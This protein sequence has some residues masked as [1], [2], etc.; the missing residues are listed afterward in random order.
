MSK[1]TDFIIWLEESWPA[2]TGVTADQDDALR[3]Y[4][5]FVLRESLEETEEEE[6]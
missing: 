4:V 5:E 2:G 1:I 3:H 6:E